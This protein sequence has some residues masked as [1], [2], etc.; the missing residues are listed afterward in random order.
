MPKPDL[1]NQPPHYTQAAIEPIDYIR[2]HDM[3]FCEGNVI[4]YLTRHNH[5]ATPMQDLL[6]CRYYINKLIEDLEKEYRQV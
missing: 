4:K 3:S 6:K 1:I 2:A 5:K